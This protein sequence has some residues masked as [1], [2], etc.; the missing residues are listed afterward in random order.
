MEPLTSRVATLALDLEDIVVLVGLTARQHNFHSARVLG[1]QTQAGRVPVQLLH[2]A[3][4]KMSVRRQNLLKAS[5]DEDRAALLTRIVWERQLE[6][7]VAASFLLD[8]LR[9]E[10]G[11]CLEIASHF[12]PRE[13]LALTTGFAMGRIVPE[14]NM[15]A[16][17]GGRFVWRPLHGGAHGGANPQPGPRVHGAARI[18]DG[19]VRIDCAVVSVGSGRFVVAGGCDTHPSRAQRF[20]AS[21]F[22]YDAITNA[23]EPLPDMPCARHGCN[24]AFLDGRVYVLGG[25]YVARAPV[26]PFCVWLDVRA[27]ASA[28]NRT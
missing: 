23:V 12:P 6:L 7:R 2:G 16:L 15:V 4:T 28:S 10:K 20:F 3:R 22:M 19:I 21:A 26:A 24:G 1:A 8:K 25:E 5:R 11:L 14:W 17:E 13:T 9:G 27:P 18:T